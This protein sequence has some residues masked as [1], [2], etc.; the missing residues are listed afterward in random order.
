MQRQVDR[1]ED[2]RQFPFLAREVTNC[3][4][5]FTLK[6]GSASVGFLITLASSLPCAV[7]TSCTPRCAMHC[8]TFS[9]TGACQYG[10]RCR[11]IHA[12]PPGSAF[13]TPRPLGPGFCSPERAGSLGD[14][15]Y[16]CDRDAS[17][18]GVAGGAEG[19]WSR[20]AEGGGVQGM[21][22]AAAASLLSPI[23]GSASLFSASLGARAGARHML[24]SPPYKLQRTAHLPT[25]AATAADSAGGTDGGGGVEG[26]RGGVDTSV[27]LLNGGGAA[28]AR[29]LHGAGS[30]DAALQLFSAFGGGQA[31]AASG[32]ATA[33]GSPPPRPKQPRSGSEEAP[34]AWAVAGGGGAG[35]QEIPQ[36]QRQQPQPQPQPQQGPHSGVDAVMAEREVTGGATEEG[37]VAAV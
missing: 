16:E 17:P 30:L 35:V 5:G 36:P 33:M 1:C 10:N 22:P 3:E 23:R 20:G 24:S 7:A 27:R 12:A 13:G 28:A 15:E 37:E 34:A 31:A 9:A 18:A 6:P 14:E 8:R 11:F 32:T 4:I 21:L 25:T 19:L 26:A 29:G 2:G